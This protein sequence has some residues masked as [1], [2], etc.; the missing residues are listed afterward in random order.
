MANQI[1]VYSYNRLILN[2]KRNRVL[3]HKTLK[4]KEKTLRLRK[5]SQARR[6]SCCVIPFIWCSKCAKLTYFCCNQNANCNWVDWLCQ[7]EAHKTILWKVIKILCTAI[8]IYMEIHICQNSPN[9]TLKTCAFYS[10]K[11]NTLGRKSIDIFLAV[12]W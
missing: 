9:W 5:I 11:Q 1:V 12:I 8:V 2:N 10:M 3:I 6:R 7:K 4:I